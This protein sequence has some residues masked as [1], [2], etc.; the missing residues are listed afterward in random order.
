[1]EN[2]AGAMIV[3]DAKDLV[4]AVEPEGTYSCRLQLDLLKLKAH[5]IRD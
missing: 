1:M 4:P 2:R 3:Y 5:V